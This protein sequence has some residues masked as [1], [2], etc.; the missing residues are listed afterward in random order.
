MEETG[1]SSQ[2]SYKNLG[3]IIYFIPYT[4]I[5]MRLLLLAL[6]FSITASAQHIA[7]VDSGAVNGVSYKILFPE[8]WKGKLVMYA[9][10]YEFMGSYAEAKQKS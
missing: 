10:G 4:I 7:K 8:K 6:L 9:H 3:R 2:D 5:P 1:F